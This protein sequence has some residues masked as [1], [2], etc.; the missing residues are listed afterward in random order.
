MT[1]F[2]FLPQDYQ[3]PA[4]G[5]GYMKLQDGEN[6]I[7]IL[8]HPILGW[9]DWRDKKPLR[10]TFD[11]KPA[12]PVDS[13]KP[14]K[15]FWAMVVWNYSEEA[16]Q[17]LEITQT[18]I[19]N[20]IE[21]FC[22]DADWGAPYFYDIKII[23]KG[24]GMETEYAVNPSPHKPLAPAIKE[25]FLAKPAWLPALFS[26]G[27]PF[28]D[29]PKYTTGV[30]SDGEATPKGRGATT[31]KGEAITGAQAQELI[32]ILSDCTKQYRE[33]VL[34]TIAQPPLNC[35][36]VYELAP[37]VYEKIRSAAILNRKPEQENFAGFP[38]LEAV[39]E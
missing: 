13:Q 33:G 10:F 27:D 30:F 35:T 14:V 17:I 6:R 39:N 26:N 24:D 32:D 9:E 22:K 1:S 5:G 7:R 15:H 4:S 25:A 23:R 18:T 12:K 28:A 2:N 21:G 3:A 37:N 8:S 20:S 34:K 31:A 11:A 38:G 29:H 36:T 16:I 19:R